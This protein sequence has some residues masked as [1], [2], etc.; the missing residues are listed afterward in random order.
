MAKFV[1]TTDDDGS[2]VVDVRFYKPSS[3][4]YKSRRYF[5]SVKDAATSSRKIFW[6]EEGGLFESKRS[7]RLDC[8]RIQRLKAVSEYPTGTQFYNEIRSD[9]EIRCAAILPPGDWSIKKTHTHVRLFHAGKKIAK[10][11]VGTRKVF[12]ELL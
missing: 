2:T 1:R 4:E 11:Y 10:S 7:L 5:F 12:C 9:G 6:I 8:D 3:I